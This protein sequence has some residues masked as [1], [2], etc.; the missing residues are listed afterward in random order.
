MSPLAWP[1]GEPVVGPVEFGFEIPLGDPDELTTAATQAGQT[2]TGWDS[3]AG[4]LGGAVAAASAAWSGAAQSA[5]G[6]YADTLIGI[7]DNNSGVLSGVASVLSTLASELETAQNATQQAYGQ[8]LHYQDVAQTQGAAQSQ[9]QQSAN[10]LSMHANLAP[11]PDTRASLQSR[12]NAQQQ[13]ADNAAAQVKDA[14]AQLAHWRQQGANAYNTYEQQAQAAS[15][16]ISSLQ[17]ELQYVKHLPKTA[18]IPIPLQTTDVSFIKGKLS[19]IT[20]IPPSELSKDPKKALQQI[21]GGK[22]ITPAEALLLAQIIADNPKRPHHHSSIFGDVWG[23]IKDGAD[24]SFNHVV[25]PVGNAF[26]SFGNAL[27]NDPKDALD[28]LGGLLVTAGGIGMEGGGGLLDATGI[29]LPV[30]ITIN[31][32]GAGVIAT[33]GGLSIAGAKGLGSYAGQ[34]PVDPI[35]SVGKGS[36]GGSAANTE[37]T[38]IDNIYDISDTSGIEE[39]ITDKD[40]T[41]AQRELDGETVAT[42]GDGTP[43]DHVQEVRDAQNGLLNRITKLKGLINSGK[44][45]PGASEVAQQRLGVLSRIL[46]RTEKYVPRSSSR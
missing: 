34:H 5:F 22:P 21:T 32:A 42:K 15:T 1:G 4:I 40:L 12:A 11:H 39:H 41:A 13:A 23:G 20:Q 2:A 8:C 27:L 19:A 9:A 30:G 29:G 3:D 38:Q 28:F 31:V 14:N 17:S 35:K 18:P 24:W 37:A 26:A 46:D 7:Y 10:Q 44:L 36:G 45:Q 25:K 33:G 16:K 43:Y 6:S